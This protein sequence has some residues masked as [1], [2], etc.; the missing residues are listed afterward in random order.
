MNKF[1]GEIINLFGEEL[2][3]HERCIKDAFD[4][5]EFAEDQTKWTANSEI[6]LQV[7]IL[8]KS[9]SLNIDKIKIA[10][11]EKEAKINSLLSF[12]PF[13]KQKL[14]KELTELKKKLAHLTNLF[15][16][17]SIYQ[18]VGI[19]R[20]RELNDKI[21]FDL[22]KQSRATEKGEKIG[23]ANMT[24]LVARFSN[25]KWEDVENLSV[26]EFTI[27]LEQSINMLNAETTGK[28]GTTSKA[29]EVSEWEKVYNHHFGDRVN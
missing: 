10:I 20:L 23:R 24:Q 5:N 11:A 15:T 29:Q 7:V 28:F 21:R 16:I 27:R 1:N 18:N 13:K 22:E 4:L 14:Q 6:Y 2:L 26:S 19:G 12:R 25:M 17:E 9:L 8:Q 3:L